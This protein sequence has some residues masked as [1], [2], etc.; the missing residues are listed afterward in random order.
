MN[1]IRKLTKAV[2]SVVFPAAF[3]NIAVGVVE[4]AV[5]ICT[6]V[7]PL[8]FVARAVHP[9]LSSLSVPFALEPLAGVFGSVGEDYL[10][11]GDSDTWR[12]SFF[13]DVIVVLYEC[14]FI[15]V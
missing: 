6:V 11:F 5:A 2:G 4:L 8:A 10:L 3:I 12:I 14:F 13:I 15:D 7:S 1:I 9:Y